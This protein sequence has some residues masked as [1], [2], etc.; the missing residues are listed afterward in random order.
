MCQRYK[1]GEDSAFSDF[2]G[3]ERKEISDG[4]FGQAIHN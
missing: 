3:L 2:S 1:W 4:L